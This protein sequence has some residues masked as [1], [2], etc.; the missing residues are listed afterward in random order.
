MLTFP[1]PNHFDRL[2]EVLAAAISHSSY[3]QPETAKQKNQASQP[4]EVFSGKETEGSAAKSKMPRLE[5]RRKAGG[6]GLWMDGRAGS[7]LGLGACRQVLLLLA[8]MESLPPYVGWAQ[9]W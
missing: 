5:Q 4:I 9:I 7:R 2:G 8:A 3:A 6:F 1:S